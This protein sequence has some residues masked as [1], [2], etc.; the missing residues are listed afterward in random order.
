MA[1]SVDEIL[2]SLS[3]RIVS[4]GRNM[5]TTSST[6]QYGKTA[7]R[8]YN[9]YVFRS[10]RLHYCLR[11][12]L[13]LNVYFKWDHNLF[14]R[15]LNVPHSHCHHL[16]ILYSYYQISCKILSRS[17]AQTKQTFSIFFTTIVSTTNSWST[18]H[19][20]ARG[21]SRNSTT[22]RGTLSGG[23]TI[24]STT[25]RFTYVIRW[26]VEKSWLDKLI[27]KKMNYLLSG[28]NIYFVIVFP[29]K[30][31]NLSLTRFIVFYTVL[32]TCFFSWESVLISLATSE[33]K[34]L[35]LL[36]DRIVSPGR[37]VKTTSSTL[38]Y[39]KTACR[40]YKKYSNLRG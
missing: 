19:H 20:L 18:F 2:T 16:K 14:C 38:Q 21:T 13:S 30:K 12:K 25:A 39:G 6:L 35:A 27:Q 33:D 37:N 5:I 22:W 3:D 36:S 4:P 23:K 32:L 40:V 26:N 1:T 10:I 29:S 34:T 15:S 17:Q 7:C 24:W 8:V 11:T 31:L 28:F 9:K